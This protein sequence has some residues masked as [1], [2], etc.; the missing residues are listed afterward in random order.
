MKDPVFLGG[1]E[2]HAL[3]WGKEMLLRWADRGSPDASSPTANCFYGGA[4][5]TTAPG[6]RADL[7]QAALGH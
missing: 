1:S 7:G 2:R 3:F 5:Q 4:D 6:S